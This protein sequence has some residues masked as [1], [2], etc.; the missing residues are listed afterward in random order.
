MGTK[1]YDKVL[2]NVHFM[3]DG[4]TSHRTS[5]VFEELFNVYETRII[6]LDSPKFANGGM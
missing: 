6:G 4:A 2:K 5:E 3:Q 1:T